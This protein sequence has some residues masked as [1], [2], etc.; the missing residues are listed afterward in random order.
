MKRAKDVIVAEG[1]EGR[2]PFE[3]LML[4]WCVLVGAAL[5]LGTPAPGSVRELLPQWMVMTWYILL[6]TG[7]L[8]G[9]VGVWLANLTL[10]LLVERAALLTVAPG[11]LL[12]SVAL[13]SL[14]G[15]RG[16]VS[17]GLTLAFAMAAFLRVIRISVHM[18][19]VRSLIGTVT[20]T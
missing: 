15:E 18:R 4:A 7:G 14:A 17:G 3:V 12:Y 9:L 10:S 5:A 1:S 20:N 8:V 11:A 6:C 16:F 2:N 13:F 19:R